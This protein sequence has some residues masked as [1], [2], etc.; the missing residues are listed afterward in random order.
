M[1]CYKMSSGCTSHLWFW[2][3]FPGFEMIMLNQYT[4]TFLSNYLTGR[5]FLTTFKTM[6][7][8]WLLRMLSICHWCWYLLMIAWFDLFSC[9]SSLFDNHII[10][11]LVS[12]QDSIYLDFDNV[13]TNLF[14][15][16][17]WVFSSFLLPLV[18]KLMS[19]R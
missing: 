2:K 11:I 16:F 18:N 1:P 3:L 15:N 9:W 8:I 19:I 5:T 7:C 6:Y 4:H 10:Q 14:P 17:F 13:F 12:S